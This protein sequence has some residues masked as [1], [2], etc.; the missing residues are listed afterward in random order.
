MLPAS[1]LS[2]QLLTALQTLLK[3][4]QDNINADI[5]LDAAREMLIQNILTEDIFNTVFVGTQFHRENNIARELQKVA[6]TLNGLESYCG[7]IKQSASGIA[8]H[9]EKQQFLGNRIL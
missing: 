6:D 3:L 8:N 4:C 2:S 5:V 7:A 1:F 9:H